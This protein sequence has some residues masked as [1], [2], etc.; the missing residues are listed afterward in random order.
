[1]NLRAAVLAAAGLLASPALLAEPGF[2]VRNEAGFSR[3]T[4][5]P[6]LGEARVLDDGQRTF[7]LST[8]WS[9]EYVSAGNARESLLIDS[10]SERVS[11]ELRQ[12]VAPGVELGITVPLL[13]TG[14]GALDSVIE[15]WHEAFGLPNGGR[16]RR[17]QDRYAVQYV[18]DGQT[19]IDLDHGSRGLGDVELSAGFALRPDFAFRA[20]AKLPTGRGSRLLGGNAGGAFWFDYNPF[21]GIDRWFGYLSAGA[22]YNE[23]VH[24]L[25]AQ[26]QQLIGLGGVGL[27]YRLLPALA[28]ITQFNV[29]TP[30]YKDAALKALDGPGGQLAFG[31]RIRLN[32]RLALDL[33]V[34]EDVLLSSS[35]DFSVHLGLAW[36]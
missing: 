7:S 23:Q 25:G 10:E 21:E 15:S 17:P 19:L 33:G 20:M 5:L 31:G 2:A 32:P 18:R 16:Q 14:G 30:L 29:Q 13:F 36:R 24:Y 26:Q 11:F 35:P 34:Q 27:G 4:A 28:L 9:N 6:L 1:M 3:G 8:D 12:G 22:S